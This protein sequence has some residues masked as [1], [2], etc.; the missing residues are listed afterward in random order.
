MPAGSI[1][2]AV[3]SSSAVDPI[4]PNYDPLVWREAALLGSAMTL[5]LERDRHSGVVSNAIYDYFW[6]GYEDS[7][8]LGHNTVCLLTEVASVK[9]ATPIVQVDSELT[10]H[11]RG[12]PKY[13]RT[14]DFPNPWKAG[15]W[16]LRDIVDYELIATTAL[17]E[18]IRKLEMP[19]GTDR[20]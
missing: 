9:V 1:E 11:E 19:D 10:G 5:Q 14:V 20:Q 6:P 18:K 12:L 15:R 13:E 3:E 16:T 4:D 8:P 2:W 17:L 7:A